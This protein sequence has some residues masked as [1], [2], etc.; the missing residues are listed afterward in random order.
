M[1]QAVCGARL[2]VAVGF[3]FL[4]VENGVKQFALPFREEKVGRFRHARLFIG[5]SPSWLVDPHRTRSA[6]QALERPD[7]AG[8]ALAIANAALASHLDLKNSFTSGFILDNSHVADLQ[9]PRFVGPKSS[10]DGEQDIVVE[11]FA[12]PFEALLLGLMC[13]LARRLIELLVFLR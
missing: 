11:L 6:L 12:F 13:S 2:T 1:A 7:R 4:F 9:G 10:I 5:P 3:Q 8:H